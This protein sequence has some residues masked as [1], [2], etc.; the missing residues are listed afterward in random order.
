MNYCVLGLVNKWQYESEIEYCIGNKDLIAVLSLSFFH[1]FGVRS[2][3]LWSFESSFVVRRS[4][5]VVCSFVVR[6]SFVRR[7]SWWP[8]FVRHSSFVAV[9]R[10]LFIVVH[11]PPSVVCSFVRSFVCLLRSLCARLLIES[12]FVRWACG[13]VLVNTCWP[14]VGRRL[15]VL[16]RSGPLA[17]L[18]VC[19]VGLVGQAVV[20][21]RSSV[22]AS[23]SVRR[24][25]RCRLAFDS[26]VEVKVL[27]EHLRGGLTR[28]ACH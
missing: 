23:S 12:L 8:S 26:P 16:L 24:S 4:L 20:G 5:F 10:P 13:L 22:G 7:S 25:L 11:R 6:S 3:E 19:L 21:H 28:C 14:S 18:F 15:L 1:F 9:H 17:P 27:V 2:S